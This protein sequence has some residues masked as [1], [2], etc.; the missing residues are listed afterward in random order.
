MAEPHKILFVDDVPLFRELGA[1]MLRRSGRVETAESGA[2]ALAVLRRESMDVVLTDLHM[3]DMDGETLCRLI[4]SDAALRETSVV[5]FGTHDV[6]DRARAIRAGADEV[7]SKPLERQSLVEA[8]ERL[9]KYP[10]PRGQPRAAVSARVDIELGEARL[11]GTMRNVSRGG[12]FVETSR[13]IARQIELGLCFR[14]PH[15]PTSLSPT[16]K[17]VWNREVEGESGGWGMGLQFLE[18]ESAA[19]RLLS[20]YVFEYCDSLQAFA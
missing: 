15:C 18:L 11:E 17:V 20:D 12:A 4:K 16:A 5:V 7:L 3:P 14:L 1:S 6:Q 10:V 19:S 9:A 13:R 8:V 2:Q